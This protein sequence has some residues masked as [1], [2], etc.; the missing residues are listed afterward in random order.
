MRPDFA[1]ADG[2][3]ENEYQKFYEQFVECVNLGNYEDFADGFET[4]ELLRNNT[5]KSGEVQISLKKYI[6]H[7]KGNQNEFDYNM[8]VTLTPECLIEVPIEIAEKNDDHKKLYELIVEYMRTRSHENLVDGLEVAELVRYNTLKPEDEQIRSKEY[9]GSKK[10]GQNDNYDITGEN[11]IPESL[12]D[13]YPETAE[14]NDD[15]KKIYERLAECMKPGIHV[16]FVDDFVTVE[17]VRFNTLKPEDKQNKSKEYI[18][19]KKEGQSY[20]YDITGEMNVPECLKFE[21]KSE[22]KI[23]MEARL[24]ETV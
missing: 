10:E 2:K 11:A 13:V 22:P 15:Y 23:H 14:K 8:D 20:N 12:L 16:N 21:N 6:I 18:D 9:I 4:A 1:G 3:K 7:M 17:L 5:S 19:C 24:S